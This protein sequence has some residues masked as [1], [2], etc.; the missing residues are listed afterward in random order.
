MVVV[1]D[2]WG[3]EVASLCCYFGVPL[4][5]FEEVVEGSE[6][7]LQFGVSFFVMYM[8]TSSLVFSDVLAELFVVGGIDAF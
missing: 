2:K 1:S 3:E 7:L 5:G 4:S 8:P 6:F